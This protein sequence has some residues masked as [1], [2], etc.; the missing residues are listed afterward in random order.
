MPREPIPLIR[1]GGFS[2]AEKLFILSFEG[3]GTE[4]K[5]FEDLR[6]SE[7]FNNNGLIETIPLKRVKNTGSDP[8]SVKKL[9]KQ[10]KSE[11]TF[12][13]TDEF[14]LII[15][16]DH[17]ESIHKL[18]FELLVNEC[19]AEKNFYLAMSNPCF[20]IWLVLHLTSIVEFTKQE[21]K[22]IYQNS[23]I[24]NSKNHIDTVLTKLQG[25]GYN[26]RPNPRIYLPLTTTAVKRAKAL[27]NLL[28]SYPKNIGTHI[29]KLIEKLIKPEI[30]NEEQL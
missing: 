13:T 2:N 10:A 30:Q 18:S 4:T 15:D 6:N 14:W 20:E 23:K 19:K 22:N 16:R 24:S 8:F 27:D 28:E 29:Y 12:K 25:R 11:Y 3:E 1:Q 26:K 7:I 21:L 17:W 5:Y 9:L